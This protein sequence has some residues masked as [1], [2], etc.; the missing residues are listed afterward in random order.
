MRGRLSIRVVTGFFCFV[1]FCFFHGGQRHGVFSFESWR[2]RTPKAI[3]RATNATVP[4]VVD[5]VG[6][7]RTMKQGMPNA[8]ATASNPTIR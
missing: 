4:C 2:Q 1:F 6:P 5:F 3:S 7:N 8:P